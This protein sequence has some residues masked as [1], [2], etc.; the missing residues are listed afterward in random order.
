MVLISIFFLEGAYVESKHIKFQ[1]ECSKNL[2][3]KFILQI[4]TGWITGKPKA[5]EIKELLRH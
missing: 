4:T 1:K 3:Q 5:S 2:M